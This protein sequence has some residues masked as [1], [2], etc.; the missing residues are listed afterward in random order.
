[1]SQQLNL[2]LINILPYNPESLKSRWTLLIFSFDLQVCEQLGIGPEADYFGLKI[3]KCS[4]AA[5]AVES[6]NSGGYSDSDDEASG[7]WANLRNLMTA[8]TRLRLR[9]KFWVPPHRLLLPATRHQFYLN[10]R[11]DLINGRMVV[12]D[13]DIASKLVAF[14]AQ[15]EYGDCD[16]EAPLTNLYSQY[17]NIGPQNEKPIDYVQHIIDYHC[18]MTGMKSSTAEYQVLKHISEL[19]SFGEELFFC[20][21]PGPHNNNDAHSLYTHLLYHGKDVEVPTKYNSMYAS[22]TVGCLTTGGIQEGVVE[23]CG[24][25]LGMCVGVG[26]QGIVVYRP[27]NGTG[28][29]ANE[30]QRYESIDVFLYHKHYVYAYW[31]F[32]N[33]YSIPYTSIIRAAPVRKNFQLTYLNGEGKETQLNIKMYSGPIAAALYRAVTEKHAFY[34]CETVRSDVTKQFIRDLKVKI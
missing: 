17:H 22:Q 6:N 34:C 18:G 26:P 3:S 12:A 13:W 7:E 27:G 24:C 9:V 29:D 11:R 20:K 2:I 5:D 31:S 33:L 21:P 16:P 32:I 14:I 4:P 25:K 23:G 30:K 8:Q 1:M 15:A 19:E 28:P 10:A